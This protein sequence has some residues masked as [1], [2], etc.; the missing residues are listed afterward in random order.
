MN[1]DERRTLKLLRE[2]GVNVDEAEFRR[3]C[4]TEHHQGK[5]ETIADAWRKRI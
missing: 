3:W 4:E 5:P 2:Q 1:T